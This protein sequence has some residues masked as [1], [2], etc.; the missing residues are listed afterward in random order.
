MQLECCKLDKCDYIDCHFLQLHNENEWTE[1]IDEFERNNPGAKYH[2]FGI[3]LSTDEGDESKHFYA[4]P[5]IVKKVQFS[6]WMTTELQND[7]TLIPT[8]Y[9]LEEY[10]ISEVFYSKDWFEKN[11]PAMKQCWDEIVYY[12]NNKEELQKEMDSKKRVK[13]VVVKKKSEFLYEKPLFVL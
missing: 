10:Y 8:F 2:L 13:K 7:P 1:A 6:E 3:M 5:N 12:R 9:Q 11:V 4:P